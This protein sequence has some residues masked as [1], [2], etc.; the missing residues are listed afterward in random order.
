M[1]VSKCHWPDELGNV[2]SCVLFYVKTRCY[3]FV[4]FDEDKPKEAIP[5]FQGKCHSKTTNQNAIRHAWLFGMLRVEV[6][7]HNWKID[8]LMYLLRGRDFLQKTEKTT[9]IVSDEDEEKTD[10]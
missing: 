4:F 3:C 5:L 9:K 10:E 7:W 8:V 1:R 2:I 6:D